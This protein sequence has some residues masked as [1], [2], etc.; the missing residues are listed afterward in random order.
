MR[1][2]IIIPVLLSALLLGVPSHTADFNKGMTAYNN[3]DYA[4]ALREWTSVIE[5]GFKEEGYVKT[6]YNLGQMHR[7]GK[8]VPQ[9]Y[10]LSSLWFNLAAEQGDANSQHNLG[11]AYY[12]G[13]GVIQDLVYSHMWVNI[14]MSNGHN[15]AK[16]ELE[17]IENKMT[18]S[19]IE[20][21]QKLARECAKKNY[22]GC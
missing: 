3:G 19:Q 21:A 14:A 22:K 5:K 12:K 7:Y 20:E 16:E 2:L 11:I 17:I 13:E 15:R 1:T 9:D 6:L 10:Y 18:P 8:G 4:T